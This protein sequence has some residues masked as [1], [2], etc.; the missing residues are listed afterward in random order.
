VQEIVD[1]VQSLEPFIPGTTTVSSAF[2]LLHHLWSLRLTVNQMDRIVKNKNVFVVCIGFLYLRYTHPPAKLMEWFADF[3]A[4]STPVKVEKAGKPVPVSQFVRD[5]LRNKKF[6]NSQLPSIPVAV[7][8]QIEDA[9]RDFEAGEQAEVEPPKKE[10]E[11]RGRADS[12]SSSSR[13]RSR[14]RD[15]RRSRSRSRDRHR[16]SS[17]ERRRS[18]SRDRSRDRG[19]DHERERRSSRDRDRDRDRRRDRSHDRSRE[20]RR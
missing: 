18:R 12:S 7:Q 10:E 13:S 20:R 11:K 9:I 3:L 19:K 5:L 8:K 1:R 15:R 16:N 2:C 6:C 17:R 4:D 14:S